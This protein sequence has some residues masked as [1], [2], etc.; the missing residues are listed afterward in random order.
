[1]VLQGVDGL[2]DVL[3]LDLSWL[4]RRMQPSTESHYCLSPAATGSHAEKIRCARVYHIN[5]VLRVRT[6]LAGGPDDRYTPM[7]PV[8]FNIMCRYAASTPPAS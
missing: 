6:R 3:Q 8:F 7:L 2:D 1:M 5:L 4:T